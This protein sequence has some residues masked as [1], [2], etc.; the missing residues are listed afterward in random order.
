MQLLFIKHTGIIGCILIK[1][2]KYFCTTVQTICKLIISYTFIEIHVS[3]FSEKNQQLYKK[4]N[5]LCPSTCIY[6]WYHF[7]I[8][9]FPKSICT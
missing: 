3:L 1:K 8:C 5:K 7:K 6:I 2:N 9:K 4:G